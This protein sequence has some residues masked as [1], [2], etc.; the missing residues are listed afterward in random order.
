ME[1]NKKAKIFGVIAAIFFIIFLILIVILFLIQGTSVSSDD[2]IGMMFV[3]IFG[4]FFYISIPSAIIFTILAVYFYFKYRKKT[5]PINNAIKLL[6]ER[7]AKGE[8]TKEELEKMKK[9][10]ES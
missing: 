1:G 6:Y 9:E 3:Y 5:A 8:I 2:T 7:Y 10:I 4:I